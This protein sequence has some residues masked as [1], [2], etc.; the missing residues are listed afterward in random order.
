MSCT[1]TTNI[2]DG[3]VGSFGV[4]WTDE[5]FWAQ[6]QA[7]TLSKG[8]QAYAIDQMRRRAFVPRGTE[9]PEFKELQKKNAELE[10]K[11]RKA[12]RETVWEPPVKKRRSVDRYGQVHWYDDKP[13]KLTTV[14][15]LWKEC[16]EWLSTVTINLAQL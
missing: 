6:Q 15:R 1:A 7:G 9:S 14:E 12:V 3:G 10:D 11:L 2:D 5:A 13:K 8:K 16:N 4:D